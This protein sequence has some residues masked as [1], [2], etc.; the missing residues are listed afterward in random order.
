M[1]GTD[2][3]LAC[4][5]LPEGFAK[6]SLE[7]KKVQGITEV[8]QIKSLAVLIGQVVNNISGIVESENFEG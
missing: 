8:S 7:R 2:K 3:K 1:N 4:K 6:K 5:M